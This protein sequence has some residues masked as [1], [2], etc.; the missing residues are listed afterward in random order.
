MGVESACHS[1]ARLAGSLLTVT[2]IMIE[3]I[4][5]SGPVHEEHTA[6]EGADREK[7]A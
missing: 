7:R 2:G 3:V 4:R 1:L 6:D 5:A